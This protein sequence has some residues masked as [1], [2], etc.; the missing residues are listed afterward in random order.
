MDIEI[1]TIIIVFKILEE[2]DKENFIVIVFPS[3]D[4]IN[5]REN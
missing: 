5:I 4:V 2:V 3:L 1:D